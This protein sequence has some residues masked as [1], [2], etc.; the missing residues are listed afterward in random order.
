VLKGSLR[1][2][3]T[4]ADTAGDETCGTGTGMGIEIRPTNES[5]AME[6]MMKEEACNVPKGAAYVDLSQRRASS[7]AL[8]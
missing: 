7:V 8:Y 2:R 6:K 5:N 4:R 1:D 3:E